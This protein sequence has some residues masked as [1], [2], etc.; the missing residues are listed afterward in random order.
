MWPINLL[1][2]NWCACL[3]LGVLPF[4]SLLSSLSAVH[5]SDVRHKFLVLVGYD[6]SYHISTMLGTISS[7]VNYHGVRYQLSCSHIFKDNRV[8]LSAVLLTIIRY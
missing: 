1:Y 2:N 3:G 6:I 7:I 5:F 4:L 8:W